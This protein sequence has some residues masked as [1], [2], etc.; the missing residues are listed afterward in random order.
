LFAGWVTQAWRA[1]SY[2]RL[3]AAEISPDGKRLATA[4]DRGN[5]EVWDISGLRPRK[6]ASHQTSGAY[7]Q[8]MC[9]TDAGA[10]VLC[11]LG[12]RGSELAV[13]DISR[14]R[15]R[16][17]V[18]ANDP[19]LAW[20]VSLDGTTAVGSSYQAAGTGTAIE[21]WDLTTGLP[22]TQF[23][24]AGSPYFHRV[25]IDA[26]A[27]VV[28]ATDAGNNKLCLLD[29]K[30]GQQIRDFP[31]GFD[32]LPWALSRDGNIA[33]IGNWLGPSGPI[34]KEVSIL[35]YDLREPEKQPHELRNLA[36]FYRALLSRDGSLLAVSN[37]HGIE[38]WNVR[39]GTPLA[40]GRRDQHLPFHDTLLTD[41][42][43]LATFRRWIARRWPDRTRRHR[44]L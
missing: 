39:S 33:A 18:R 32:S 14:N 35:F 31:G 40:Q 19:F 17:M 28:A 10:I 34:A 8:G 4:Y 3:T 11:Q 1:G 27:K 22:K 7:L 5:V 20:D 15:Q 6:V 43:Q 44:G 29:A 41:D 26:Q 23:K 2:Y 21:V 37:L 36:P 13:W 38:V 9:F 16:T 42:R 25:A 24:I 30:T 12:G